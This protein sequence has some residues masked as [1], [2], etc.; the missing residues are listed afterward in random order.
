MIVVVVLSDEVYTSAPFVVLLHSLLSCLQSTSFHLHRDSLATDILHALRWLKFVALKKVPSLPAPSHMVA[1]HPHDDTLVVARRSSEEERWYGAEKVTYGIDDVY[2]TLGVLRGYYEADGRG[3]EAA[4]EY[5]WD[6]RS[7]GDAD[8]DVQGEAISKYSWSDGKKTV[9]IYIELDGLDDVAEDAFRA[10]AGETNVSITIASVAGKQRTFRLTGLANEITGVKVAQKKGKQ[11][12]DEMMVPVDMRGVD[13]EFDDVEQ[14]TAKIGAKGIAEAFIKAADFTSCARGNEELAQGY[15]VCVKDFGNPRAETNE[16]GLLV[17]GEGVKMD[18]SCCL[19]KEKHWQCLRC[20][21]C[22]PYVNK[23]YFSFW[24]SPRVDPDF[25]KNGTDEF[26]AARDA[27]RDGEACECRSVFLASAGTVSEASAHEQSAEDGNVKRGYMESWDKELMD[28]GSGHEGETRVDD[29]GRRRGM[30]TDGRGG[31]NKRIYVRQGEKIR[32]MSEEE[33]VE[34]MGNGGGNTYAVHDG[35]I[36]T[37]EMINRLED[38][39]MI[40]LVSRLP[41]GGRKKK[42]VP[43]NTGGENTSATEES[44][45]STLSSDRSSWMTR[46]NEAFGGDAVEQMK[47]IASTG[48]GGWTEAW[49]RK[50]MEVGEEVAE[51]LLGCLHRAM[52]DKFGHGA[53]QTMIEGIRNFV[54]EQEDGRDRGKK[55]G[56][57][58]RRQQWRRGE[59][60]WES[61]GREMRKREGGAGSAIEGEEATIAEEGRKGGKGV[62]MSGGWFWQT[63]QQQWR[64]EEVE[65]GAMR[66][67]QQEKAGQEAAQQQQQREE[68]AVRQRQQQREE[69]AAR[70]RQRQREE[71]AARQRQQ[72]REEEAAR[73][74]QQQREEEEARRRQQEEAAQQQQRQQEE[75]AQRQR[76]QQEED[77]RRWQGGRGEMTKREGQ[78][79][80]DEEDEK[81]R[82]EEEWQGM[83]ERQGIQSPMIMKFGKYYGKTCEWVYSRD[84]DYCDWVIRLEASNKNL[85]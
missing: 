68:E 55:D 47:S 5:Q 64:Q 65:Q 67:G 28:S 34:W 46:M 61:I 81:R 59:E 26:D 17:E 31:E 49:A 79:R 7:G 37:A 57:E 53:A 44:S 20:E 2:T 77:A 85:L 63:G 40:R 74:R 9:S 32:Q 24:D 38:C 83:E 42:A 11:L 54:R 51:K 15:Q 3:H 82:R 71:E 4:D 21:M 76:Q 36:V 25:V 48:P 80:R 6:D 19:M 78:R 43:K 69:E 52:R 10:E 62:G 12:I 50:V 30:T 41:G 13:E 22:S 29:G 35:K 60:A 66:Q 39:V 18:T 27:W 73:Q 14:M 84:R 8:K 58:E 56:R 72:Q 45:S 1:E 75:A 16:A 23:S 70:Q 33:L